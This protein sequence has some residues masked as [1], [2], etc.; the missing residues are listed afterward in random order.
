MAPSVDSV[1]ERALVGD[2]AGAAAA[3]LGARGAQLDLDE[4]IAML[5]EVQCEIGLR[6]QRNE[7]TPAHEHAATAIVDA[8]LSKVVPP[9]VAP[10]RKGAI[11]VACAEEE[12]HVFP[13]RLLAELLRHRGW[14]VTFLGGS[15]PADHL[16]AFCHDIRPDAV[17]LSC[18]LPLHLRGARDV[19]TAAHRAGSPV[20]V[21]GS[22]F[23]GG[24][25]RGTALGADAWARTVDEADRILD[26]WTASPPTL[27]DSAPSS[28]DAADLA[29]TRHDIVDAA[30]AGVAARFPGFA[31]YTPAQRDRTREDLAYVLRFV[32]AALEVDDES[33]VRDMVPWFT[34]VLT[35]RGVPAAVVALAFD[36][37]VDATPPSH[38][39]AHRMLEVGRALATSPS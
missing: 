11:V 13:A 20:I 39:D 31:D 6:W 4:V 17:A 26:A 21:G 8:L 1:L 22:G 27:H 7:I 30:L 16:E 35:T 28:P 10:A 23:G 12:W 18:T 34:E 9:P 5:A 36:V 24:S 2:A 14:G 33:V 29:A 32:E 15:I 37:L 38:V 19:I 25:E 3:A